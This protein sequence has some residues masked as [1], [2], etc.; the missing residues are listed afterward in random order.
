MSADSNHLSV[1]AASRDGR[2]FT[3]WGSAEA[4][5]VPGDLVRLD[6]S[7]ARV[8]LGQVLDNAVATSDRSVVDGVGMVIGALGPDGVP[9]RAGRAPFSKATMG[10]AEA[11]HHQALQDSTGAGLAIGTWRSSGVEVPARLRAQGFNR[12][13]FLCGQ[14]GSGKTYALG[15]LLEQ[16]LLDTKL[17]MVV[18][19]PNADFVK[20]GETRPD[21][22]T[23]AAQR[24]RDLDVRVLRAS[25][26]GGE[27]LRMRFLGMPRQAQAAVLQLDP[28]AD[29]AE[30]SL[31]RHVMAQTSPLSVGDLVQDLLRGGQDER[32]LVQRM[33]NLGLLDWEVWA[34][35]QASAYEVVQSG[36]RVTVMDLGGF[37]DPLEPVAVSLDLVEQLWANRESR[38]PT[39]IVLDEAH[40]LCAATPSNPVQA[41]SPTG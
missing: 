14:S 8:F 31:F 34:A 41:R 20:I 4:A 10:P 40:N 39:L 24:I 3:Y 19:D 17:R 23:E 21:A 9:Q 5:F 30:Y 28:L 18:L 6:T 7:D 37:E 35:E 27:P 15:V 32:A 1:E 38:V 2:T 16:L 12:H 22:P 11:V 26:A 25:S 29:R 36:A 13:T 33:E